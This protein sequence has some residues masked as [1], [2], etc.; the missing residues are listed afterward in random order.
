MK[1]L[2]INGSPKGDR[3]N[4]YKLAKAFLAGM[5]EGAKAGEG[6]FEVEEIQVNRQDIH[7]CLGC[8]SCW[9]KTPGVCCI[10]DDMR[11]VIQKLLWADV[12][13]WSFPLYYF[14]VPGGL[15]NLIDRQLPMVQPFMVENETQTGNGS[16]PARYDM[17]GKKTVVISTCG[18]TVSEGSAVNEESR[19]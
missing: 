13:I 3:S 1:I 19:K 8:F 14:T 7:P 15:K 6:S 17:S 10:K 16:H 4:T 11:D 2:V 5:E 12:T 9:S 18:K